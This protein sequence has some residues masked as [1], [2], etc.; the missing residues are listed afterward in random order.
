MK[1]LFYLMLIT[2]FGIFSS[3]TE[4]NSLDEIADDVTPVYTGAK[5]DVSFA[6]SSANGIMLF[7]DDVDVTDIPTI[8]TK[9]SIRIDG[10]IPQT[11][12][13][14]D[15]YNANKYTTIKKNGKMFFGTLRGDY[16][17]SDPTTPPRQSRQ[18]RGHDVV[19]YAY[20]SDGSLIDALI[21]DGPTLNEV[22][23]S[24]PNF[25]SN[26]NSDGL[27][28]IW[29]VA[30]MQNEVL[31]GTADYWHVD[32]ILTFEDVTSIDSIPGLVIDEKDIVEDIVLDDDEELPGKVEV[33]IHQQLHNDW[34]EIKTTIHIRDTVNV[35][36]EL[37]IG[38]DY[39]IEQDDFKIRVWQAYYTIDNERYPIS[40][41][42]QHSFDKIK[43]SVEGITAALIRKANDE[44]EG[45]GLTIE[46]SS[47][48]ND[49]MTDELAFYLMKQAVVKTSKKT[50]INGQITS[51]FYDEVFVIGQE[52]NE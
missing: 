50:T 32:G 11:E 34:K 23:A 40:V 24:L 38:E 13:Y 16:E 1:K 36:V 41:S 52:N 2:L 49:V 22:L 30:K 21:I 20:S 47:Y 28:V 43:I 45:D 46:V 9:F 37:P 4:N 8:K 42:V 15:S 29:Y 48:Y 25:N 12:Q 7:E 18:E 5:T 19:K 39:I 10:R 35:T 17:Y 14:G 3:C 6:K 27:K 33:D 31:W 51:A 26:T 44:S